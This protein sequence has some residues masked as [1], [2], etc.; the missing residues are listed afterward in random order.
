MCPLSSQKERWRGGGHACVKIEK[1]KKMIPGCSLIE[2]QDVAGVHQD[3]K[4]TK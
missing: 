3:K 1:R 2:A 4:E